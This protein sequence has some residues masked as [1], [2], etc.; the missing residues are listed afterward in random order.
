MRAHRGFTFVG[1]LFL[2][3]GAAGIY[4]IVAFGPAYW[5][6]VEVGKTL[7]EAANM[8]MRSSDDKVRDF[9]STKLDQKFDTGA[10]DDRG[11]RVLWIDY[12][13]YK[14]LRIERTDEPKNVDIW[15]TYQRHVPLPLIGGERVLTFNDH[16]QQDLSPVKW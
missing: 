12:D 3:A 15:V 2:L 1:L 6:N 10:Y 13:P 7:H 11:N 8:C 14:D 16:V 5:D 4:S 9:I